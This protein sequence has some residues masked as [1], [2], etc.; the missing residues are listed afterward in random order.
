M[1]LG[2]S[3]VVKKDGRS[4]WRSLYAVAAA[5]SILGVLSAFQA[6]IASAATPIS[7]GAQ[8][9]E[10]VTAT[11]ATLLAEVEPH[12]EDTTYKLEYGQSGSLTVAAEGDA[13]SGS[14]AVPVSVRVHGLTA[15]RRYE[16]RVVAVNHSGTGEVSTV[17]MTQSEGA[18]SALLD[19]RVYEQVSPEDKHG[20]VFS[21]IYNEGAVIQAAADG[22]GIAYVSF[23]ATESQPEA[24]PAPEWAQ[25]LSTRLAPGVWST[26]DI[27]T[28]REES[29][30]LNPG[31][32][33]EYRV[34]SQD[35]SNAVVEPLDAK[36]LSPYATERTA[37]L[38]KDPEC[39]TST[40]ECYTPLLTSASG[41][42]DVASGTH[43]DTANGG[44]N[45]E[46]E[47][48][49]VQFAGV[50]PDARSVVVTSKVPLL[51]GPVEEAAFNG[52]SGGAQREL[53]EWSD[54]K[55]RPVSVLP[56]GSEASA[57]CPLLGYNGY[58]NGGDVRKAIS[59]DGSLVVWEAQEEG[60][61][62]GCNGEHRLYLR[63]TTT[64]MT[65]KLD[66]DNPGATGVEQESDPVYSTASADDSTV[67]FTDVVALTADSRDQGKGEPPTFNPTRD[68]YACEVSLGVGGPQCKLSDLTI[69]T[70]VSEESG[71]VQGV[72]GASEDG[73]T[74]YVVARGVL[75]EAP[76][77]RGEIPNSG[78]ENLYLLHREAPGSW[79]PAFI[80]T[81]SGTDSPDWLGGSGG[82]PEPDNGFTSR[83]SP[84]GRYLA[85]MS[86]KSLTDYD[87]RDV[88]S[89]ESDE[90][91]FLYRAPAKASEVGQLICASCDPTGARPAGALIQ[92][93]KMTLPLVERVGTWNGRWLA[94]LVPG[95]T[96]N[97]LGAAVYQSRYLSSEGRL[98]F[99]S[100]DALVPQDTNDAWNVY[101]FEPVGVGSCTEDSTGFSAMSGGCVG[102]VSSGTSAEESAFLDASESGGDV[103][104]LTSSK[105][106]PQD[107]DNAI[108]IYDAHECTETAPCVPPTVAAPQC[109]TTESCREAPQPQPAVFGAPPSATFSG[110]G[111][112]VASGSNAIAKRKPVTRAQQ[113]AR[114]LRGCR[115][116]GNRKSRSACER[117]ARRLYARAGSRSGKA[118]RKGQR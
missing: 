86:E 117:R 47:A 71:R 112:L 72:L 68:L 19:G 87:N 104:F 97:N 94:A 18:E 37:Y 98:F 7:I 25:I 81:L 61:F 35:L 111:D 107:S 21:P 74:V 34:F 80:V 10:N 88:N 103:F 39:E 82:D 90:E 114:A 36:P 78:Q 79:R 62:G 115:K 110:Q 30:G 67:F 28:P 48:L 44:R 45:G 29:L 2:A 102:L 20:A 96:P 100:R 53:Y 99:N 38:R 23:S 43:F 31:N 65:I 22:G 42:A 46:L 59:I 93:S 83:V 91:V 76:N 13:G 3:D 40:G 118:S 113:L 77:A 64:G 33:S 109:A 17:F 41:H 70:V 9:V 49:P 52:G 85:F 12:G 58:V 27:S 106:V 63:D 116:E 16:Y 15:N 8:S 101:E 6:S 11:G 75:T 84:N 60:E 69:P 32:L 1:E 57:L 95:W 55:L 50:S 4:H 24:E 56:G 105:L 92:G 14:G 5:T 66:A 51:G 26:R 73:S 108:D 89:G 54:G